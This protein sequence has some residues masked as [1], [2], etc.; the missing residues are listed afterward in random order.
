MNEI[1][2]N[3]FLTIG[4]NDFINKTKNNI[5]EYYVIEC[6]HAIYGQSLI[7]AYNN[8]QAYEFEKII[9]KYKLNQT[10]YEDFMDNL[11]AY[12]N[13]KKS[14][15]TNPIQKT[16]VLSNIQ[17]DII[18]MIKH[19]TVFENITDAQMAGFENIF[20][21]DM[22][23]KKYTFNYSI[24]PNKVLKYYKSEKR[25]FSEDVILEEEKPNLLDEF[26]Y[27]R[28]GVSYDDVK[29][30]DYRMIN[31]LN[32]YIKNKLESNNVPTAIK[33][34]FRI[35]SVLTSGSGAVDALL[36]IAI[37]ATEISIGLI[38]LFLHM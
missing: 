32:D 7:E 5:F 18:K 35:N 4:F 30:M 10:I 8:K 16:E 26:T 9:K 31:K 36:I 3:E 6:L 14:L 24:D 38:Y 15:I 25:S 34:R 29:D 2:I 22:E 11:I 21:N 28:F 1:F 23:I 33:Q 20:L 12:E 27:A 19:K 13:F 37:I 17:I